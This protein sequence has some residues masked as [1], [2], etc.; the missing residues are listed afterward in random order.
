MMLVLS[1]SGLMML[2]AIDARGSILFAV[3]IPNVQKQ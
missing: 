1:K 2:P 3:G